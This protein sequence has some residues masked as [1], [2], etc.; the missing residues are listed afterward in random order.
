ML[1]SPQPHLKRNAVESLE[2]DLGDEENED[3]EFEGKQITTVETS[4]EWTN[5]RQNLA[6]EMFDEWM[7]NRHV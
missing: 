6:N 2:V 4:E 3:I 7:Q 5:W 1:S